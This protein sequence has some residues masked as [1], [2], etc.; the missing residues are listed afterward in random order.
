[1]QGPIDDAFLD[2]FVFVTPSGETSAWVKS[3]QDRAIR[4]WKRMWR[5]DA[6]V[7]RDTEVTDAD[8]ADSNLVLWGD[9]ASNR[10]LA[11]IM[12]RLPVRWAG[13]ELVL[14]SRKWPAASHVPI[15]IY[16][17]PLNPN[18]YVVLNSGPTQR[19]ADYLT[20]A[21]QVPRLPDY[22]VVDTTTP[23][24]ERQ[25]GKIVAAGFFDEQWQLQ[26]DDGKGG[27]D[28]SPVQRTGLR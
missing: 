27:N 14:G 24:D 12:D 17:N 9:A 11:R 28:G 7:R 5:G 15:L 26:L 23:A 8:I 16:P 19:E 2:S 6:Q 13:G 1:M 22:A 4:E 3:E 18:R 20:N 21:R 10:L 25:P